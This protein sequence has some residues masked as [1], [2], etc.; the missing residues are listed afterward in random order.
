M[1][2][3]TNLNGLYINAISRTSDG[4]DVNG[5]LYQVILNDLSDHQ[6][7][8]FQN[9][10]YAEVGANGLTN[11]ALLHV[12]IHRMNVLNAKF[13]CRENALVIIKM[14]EALMWLNRRTAER[15]ARGV[16]GKHEA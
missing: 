11:E 12:L 16:E 8:E 14:E 3:H 1:R 5:H 7:L 9:G 15:Q 2:I 13:P 4:K 6:M 10:T